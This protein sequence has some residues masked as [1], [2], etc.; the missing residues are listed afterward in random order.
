VGENEVGTSF[1][2]AGFKVHSLLGPGL[3]ESA[4]RHCIVQELSQRGLRVRTEVPIA[5]RY[6]GSVINN[7]L[8]S[9]FDRK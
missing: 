4:Y 6:E 1:L 9:R 8:S 5:I 3:L 7:G 2:S